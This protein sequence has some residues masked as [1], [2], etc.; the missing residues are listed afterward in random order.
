MIAFLQNKLRLRRIRSA[1]GLGLLCPR[2]FYHILFADSICGRIPE[3]TAHD[4]PR[5]HEL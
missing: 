3:A 2:S 5:I 4:L 1:Q